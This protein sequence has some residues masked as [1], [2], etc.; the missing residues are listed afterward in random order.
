MNPDLVSR[1]QNGCMFP[2]MGSVFMPVDKCMKENGCLQVLRGSHKLGRIQ[3][4]L[5]GD[6]A[7]ADDER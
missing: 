7:G 1:Y 2:D 3:H 6:Q 4:C 5:V